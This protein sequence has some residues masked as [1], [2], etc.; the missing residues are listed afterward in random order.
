MNRDRIGKGCLKKA[1]IDLSSFYMK[2][3][4]KFMAEVWKLEAKKRSTSLEEECRRI[5]Q[6]ANKL[7]KS[8]KLEEV[9]DR[10]RRRADKAMYS[11]NEKKKPNG[12]G[13][14]KIKRSKFKKGDICIFY[15]DDKAILCLINQAIP[16]YYGKEPPQYEI[17]IDTTRYIMQQ[18]LQSMAQD[19]RSELTVKEWQDETM[20]IA[21]EKL[22]FINHL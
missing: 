20:I 6:R 8:G 19:N 12:W 22:V 18:T 2:E 4:P 14:R 16:D 7:L 15:M 1:L 10:A 9:S 11:K 21:E 13:N 5:S 17:I 3:N